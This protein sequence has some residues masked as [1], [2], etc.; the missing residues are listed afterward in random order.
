MSGSALRLGRLHGPPWVNALMRLG[1]G[2]ATPDSGRGLCLWRGT[3][4]HG[5]EG[6]RP[7]QAVSEAEMGER[8]GAGLIKGS[9]VVP[10]SPRLDRRCVQ[11]A[12]S[13]PDGVWG[14][15]DGLFPSQAGSCSRHGL[16]KPAVL[17]CWVG[18]V[19]SQR[20]LSVH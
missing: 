15:C 19:G 9:E 17:G 2:E 18:G 20:L 12:E 14:S 3:L 11:G 8:G 7:H 16:M 6:Q 10:V 13:R 5:I 1:Q 4:V